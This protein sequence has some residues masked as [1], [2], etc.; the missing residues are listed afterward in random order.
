MVNAT[1]PLSFVDYAGNSRP[2]KSNYARA[3]LPGEIP[4]IDVAP[5]LA[6]DALAEDKQAVVD[7]VYDA[8]TRVG[9]MYIKGHG[10]SQVAMDNAFLE[11]Q[12]FFSCSE[13]EKMELYFKLSPAFRGYEPQKGA[14]HP[15][16]HL[17][18]AFNIGYEPQYDAPEY[19]SLKFDTNVAHAPN[20]W[21]SAPQTTGLKEAYTKYFS[22]VISLGRAMIKI[23]ALALDLPETFFEDKF[24]QPGVMSRIL[25]YPPQ[26]IS[27]E[28]PLGIAEH[29]DVELFTYLLQG[30]GVT[31]LHVLS[32][33]GEWIEAPPIPGTL[34]LN[35]ADLL[36]RW[37]NGRFVST[38]HRV[39]NTTGKARY[40]IP[41]FFGPS[42][43]TLI[44][45]I[46]TCILPGETAKYAP[47]LS[48]EYNYRRSARSRLGIPYDEN[49]SIDELRAKCQELTAV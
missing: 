27:D 19:R 33:D 49:M 18:E 24:R 29:T 3:G 25:Y 13:E 28:V 10:L 26:P 11:A 22:A 23:F 42:Y 8:C 12:N 1:V 45:T 47:I 46:P 5:F 41:V 34:V 16:G 2:V 35:I 30:D 9:F 15:Q 36:S 37:T 48:G 43:N 31:A 4:I 40:S 39:V 44:E 20:V 14:N 17:K 38:C 7:Q 6:G 21:P 32:K